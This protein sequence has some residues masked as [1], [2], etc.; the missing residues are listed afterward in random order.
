[1]LERVDALKPTSFPGPAWRHVR[2]EYP[3]LSG[4]GARII[5]GRWNP[6]ES[7]PT[8]YLGLNVDIVVAEFHRHLA[9]QGLRA[10]D[11]LPRVLYEYAV[12]LGRVLDLRDPDTLQ[13]LGLHPDLSSAPAARCQEVGE[14][15]HYLGLEGILASSAAGSGDVLAVYLDRQLPDSTLEVTQSSDWEASDVT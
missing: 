1:M 9:R 14:A 3:P 4:E 8:L 10:Q 12:R 7:F 2:P 11:A 15:A 13:A 5:G 6:P